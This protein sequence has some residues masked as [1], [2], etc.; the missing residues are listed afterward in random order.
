MYFLCDVRIRL[1]RRSGRSDR[2]G[3]ERGRQP[4]RPAGAGGSGHVGVTPGAIALALPSA[5]VPA[6]GPWGSK[7]V[8][9]SDWFI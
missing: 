5:L 3:G 2:R 1:G 4:F 7:D 6:V 8:A 9:P